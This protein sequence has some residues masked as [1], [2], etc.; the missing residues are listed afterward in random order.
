MDREEQCTYDLES[1][2]G[3]AMKNRRCE[4]GNVEFFNTSCERAYVSETAKRFSARRVTD[5]ARD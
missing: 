5:T 2:Q 3:T 4:K 1:C